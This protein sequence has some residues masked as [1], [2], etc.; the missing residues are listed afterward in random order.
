[1]YQDISRRPN[2]PTPE[3]NDWI[4]FGDIA[5][6]ICERQCQYVSRHIDP[7][8]REHGVAFLA[9]GLRVH[10]RASDYHSFLIHRADVAAFVE[11]FVAHYIGD[12]RISEAVAAKIK[13]NLARLD[14]L[15]KA[16]TIDL[17][18]GPPT[19]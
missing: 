11:R 9:E 17:T 13:G 12:G 3:P 8:W 18:V 2:S 19:Q 4:R 6:Q 10:T 14:A 7:A 16:G 5:I 15:I 1:M